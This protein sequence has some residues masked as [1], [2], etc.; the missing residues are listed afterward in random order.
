MYNMV[1]IFKLIKKSKLFL[2]KFNSCLPEYIEIFVGES[3]DLLDNQS[4]LFSSVNKFLLKYNLLP[5]F[6]SDSPHN[7]YSCIDAVWRLLMKLGIKKLNV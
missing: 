4:Q 1:N 6:N 7:A 3:I 5:G 2:Q